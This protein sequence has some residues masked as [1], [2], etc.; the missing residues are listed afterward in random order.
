MAVMR[1]FNKK[2]KHGENKSEGK[3]LVLTMTTS[4]SLCFCMLLPQVVNDLRKGFCLP[5]S[6]EVFLHQMVKY[7]RP[8]KYSFAVLLRQRGCLYI[9]ICKKKKKG[10]FVRGM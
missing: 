10:R 5:A 4:T 7:Y 6:G 1:F 8:L 9:F 2:M 3:R